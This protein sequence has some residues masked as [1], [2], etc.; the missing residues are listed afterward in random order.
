MISFYYLHM[1][2]PTAKSP[3]ITKQLSLIIN[4]FVLFYRWSYNG[5]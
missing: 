3:A 5:Q 2:Q 4:S 1:L